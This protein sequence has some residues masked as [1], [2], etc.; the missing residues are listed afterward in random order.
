MFVSQWAIEQRMVVSKG[1]PFL[2]LFLF[3]FLFHQSILCVQ[4]THGV[5]VLVVLDFLVG[6]GLGIHLLVINWVDVFQ[7]ISL[8][9]RACWY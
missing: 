8:L 5:F 3:L 6:L 9:V 2:F 7:Q 1:F 4:A